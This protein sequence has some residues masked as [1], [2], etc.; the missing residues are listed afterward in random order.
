MATGDCPFC[1]KDGAGLMLYA[2]GWPTRLKFQ[3][4]PIWLRCGGRQEGRKPR[5]WASEE[6]AETPR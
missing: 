1:P 3:G 2:E 4:I 5:L 6:E